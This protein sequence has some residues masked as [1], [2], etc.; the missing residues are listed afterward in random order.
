MD[1]KSIS[2][3]TALTIKNAPQFISYYKCFVSNLDLQFKSTARVVR[4]GKAGCSGFS[5]TSIT[6]DEQQPLSEPVQM[7][8]KKK[9]DELAL[10]V[11]AILNCRKDP[12]VLSGFQQR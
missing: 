2:T 1:D 10:P 6:L 7:I 3:V 5:V 11:A 8:N 9:S 4:G 12:L